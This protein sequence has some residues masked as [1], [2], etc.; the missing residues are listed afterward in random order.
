MLKTGRYVPIFW[1]KINPKT[2]IIAMVDPKDATFENFSKLEAHL[3]KLQVKFFAPNSKDVKNT[4]GVT[5]S[6]PF[7]LVNGDEGAL[8]ADINEALQK[9]EAGQ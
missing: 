2:A 5:N 1:K 6:T 9:F 4:I 7:Y 8:E 3:A